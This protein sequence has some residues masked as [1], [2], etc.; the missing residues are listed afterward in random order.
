MARQEVLFNNLINFFYRHENDSKKVEEFRDFLLIYNLEF[1]EIDYLYKIFNNRNVVN[2][3]LDNL[4]SIDYFIGYIKTILNYDNT[5]KLTDQEYLRSILM[6]QVIISISIDP[7]NFKGDQVSDSPLFNKL[8]RHT[9]HDEKHINH[10]LAFFMRQL[11][12]LVIYRNHKLIK[13]EAIRR[14][15]TKNDSNLPRDLYVNVY[16]DDIIR[17]LYISFSKD[18]YVLDYF[19]NNGLDTKRDLNEINLLGTYEFIEEYFMD[20]LKNNERRAIKL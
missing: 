13:E 8:S 20:Y 17:E 16:C 14:Y 4:I 15:D 12:V 10:K 7:Y 18:Q 1:E 6:F 5:L 11:L 3:Y 2:A 9:Y 19:Y